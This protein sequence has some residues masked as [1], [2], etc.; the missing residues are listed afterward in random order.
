MR[1][2]ERQD[3]KK[4]ASGKP[5][6]NNEPQRVA[7]LPPGASPPAA[8]TLGFLA[9]AFKQPFEKDF[10]D[11]AQCLLK[12]DQQNALAHFQGAAALNPGC[13]D[14]YLLSALV[15]IN[16]QDYSTAAA[17]LERVIGS[18]ASEF[19]LLCK[20]LGSDSI[21]FEL[22]ITD[23]VKA[24]LRLDLRAAYLTLAEVYQQQGRLQDS[25]AIVK[26]AVSRGYSDPVIRLSLVELYNDLEMDEEL[27]AEA[28]GTENTDNVSVAILFYLGQAM[29][30]QG[31][32]DA[33]LTV[34]KAALAKRKDR[35]ET[36]L[37]DT[38]YVL[39]QVYEKSGKKSMA[40]KQYEQILA[41]DYTFRDVKSRVDE[42][43]AT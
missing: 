27:I 30:R 32:Y 31:Y 37:L 9:K 8:A 24:N 21:H 13:I 39:A 17:W 40:R 16:R 35:S 38:R 19:P 28:Q 41:K 26:Q 42:L 23:E 34:L 12:D 3:W 25:L 11:G 5:A 10:I 6:Q 15:L 2:E 29:M 36:L 1:Y 18:G 4:G 20:Y 7:P 33:A 43:S 22:A 14:A